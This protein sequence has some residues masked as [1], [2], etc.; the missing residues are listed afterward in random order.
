MYLARLDDRRG[1][2][3]QLRRSYRVDATSFN[4]RI[5]FDLGGNPGRFIEPFGDSCVLFDSGLLAAVA[6]ETDDDGDR[7]LERLLVD[8]LPPATKRRLH[9]FPPRAAAHRPTPIS[10]EEREEIA[11]Q[12]HLFDRRRLYYLR[13]GA[14]DQSRLFRLHE[15]CCRPLL[16]Q[17]RDEREYAFMAEEAGLEPGLYRQYVYAIF[18]VQKHFHQSFAPWFPEALAQDEVADCFLKELCRLNGDSNFWQAEVAGTS[19]HLHL[20][21]Y[22]VMF[23]DYRPA[24]RSFLDDFTEAFRAGHRRFRWPERKPAHSPEKVSEI[25][26]TPYAELRR[27]SGAQLIRLY[28]QK[29]LRLHPDLGGDHDLFIE[30]TEAYNNLRRGKKDP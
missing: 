28:R 24:S 25:F 16:G 10:P 12:V 1:T 14:V 26:A 9:L 5:V 3:Y 22:L 15:K 13:Y 23:F 21:R 20:R 11:R 18:D 29:A 27:M 17:C 7:V 6:A 2:R 4:Y 30:L 19:L 8:F